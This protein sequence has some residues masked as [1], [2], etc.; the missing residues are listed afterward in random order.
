MSPADRPGMLLVVSGPSGAGKTSIK[1]ALLER[2]ADAE[3]SVSATTRAKTDQ[4]RDGVDYHFL[5]RAEFQRRVDAGAFLEHAEYAG[6]RYGT[7]RAPVEDALR[8]GR[9]MILD[10]DVQGARQI[11]AAMPEAFGL[12]VLPPSDQALADRLRAR[13]RDS[14]T[15]IVRRLEIARQELAAAR[16]EGLYDAFLV[17]RDLE[18]AIEE[19]VA[20]VEKARTARA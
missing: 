13:G 8:A 3:F 9:I 11:R 5:D 14:E 6:N 7:L 12:F 1:N 18:K 17:N 19:A 20:I 16:E 4:E 15:A 2:F 10:V